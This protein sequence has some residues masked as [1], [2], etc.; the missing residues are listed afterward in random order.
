MSHVLLK[1]QRM[2]GLFLKVLDISISIRFAL[3]VNV[4]IQLFLML[5]D[6]SNT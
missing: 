5:L 3:S 1:I 6:K 2:D 4:K